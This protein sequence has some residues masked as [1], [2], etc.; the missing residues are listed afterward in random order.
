[1]KEEIINE[2][3]LQMLPYLNNEQLKH[4]QNALNATLHNV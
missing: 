1:M 2:I 4:L 3:Q